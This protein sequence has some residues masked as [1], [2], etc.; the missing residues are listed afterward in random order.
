MQACVCVQQHPRASGSVPVFGS[1]K[2]L[3]SGCVMCHCPRHDTSKPRHLSRIPEIELSALPS[4]WGIGPSREPGI[5]VQS[6]GPRT[7]N[8]GPARQ[9]V[10]GPRASIWGANIAVRCLCPKHQERGPWAVP[11]HRVPQLWA[12]RGCFRHLLFTPKR[13]KTRALSSPEA[14]APLRRV[15]LAP[16]PSRCLL[17]QFLCEARSCLPPPDELPGSEAPRFQRA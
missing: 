9:A 17:L 5:P 2:P 10:G 16:Y 13:S 3:A 8:R 1:V 12:P 7:S 15:Y 14:P 6:K 11:M 4:G